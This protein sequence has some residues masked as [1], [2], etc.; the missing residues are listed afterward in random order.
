[1]GRMRV[2]GKRCQNAKGKRCRCVCQGVTHG[3]SM[4]ETAH[5]EQKELEFVNV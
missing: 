5:I 3:K 1:M 4:T 2:C